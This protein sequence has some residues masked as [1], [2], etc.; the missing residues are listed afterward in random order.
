ML[1][2]KG[3]VIDI[4]FLIVVVIGL[5]IFILIVGKV[6]PAITSQIKTTI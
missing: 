6:F 2:K 4:A 5:S 3:S 1:N